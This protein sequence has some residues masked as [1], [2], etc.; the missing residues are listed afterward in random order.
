VSRFFRPDLSITL[1]GDTAL[2]QHKRLWK[3]RLERLQFAHGMPVEARLRSALSTLLTPYTTATLNLF[4]PSS[5][6]T[7]WNIPWLNESL[8]EAQ[9]YDIAESLA[10][11]DLGIMPGTLSYTLS[12]PRF[13]Q[14]RMACGLPRQLLDSIKAQLPDT[15]E[16]TS[17]QPLLSLAW[18]HLD[19][20]KDSILYS[21]PGFAAILPVRHAI[22][23]HTRRLPEGQ[24]ISADA[25]EAL[26]S[27]AGVKDYRTLLVGGEASLTSPPSLAL[28]SLVRAI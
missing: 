27:M 13:G 12:P 24:T 5:Q 20:R 26:A 18:P 23:I 11:Q 28:E 10:Q 3:P 14:S 6:F 1:S 25:G 22:A 19:H 4:L 2:L 16:L 15:I 7:F 17:I 9:I 21:E 8:S